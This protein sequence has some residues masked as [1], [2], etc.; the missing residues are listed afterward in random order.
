[1]LFSLERKYK[2]IHESGS[3]EAVAVAAWKLLT[4]LEMRGG[5]SFESKTFLGF[6]RKWMVKDN[7]G[8]LVQVNDAMFIF[9]RTIENVVRTVLN[10]N[11]MRTLKVKM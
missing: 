8:G 4:A 7:R 1:M 10:V 6:T 2:R 5:R 3:S 9:V 11:L